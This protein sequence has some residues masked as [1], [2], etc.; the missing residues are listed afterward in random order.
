MP[1]DPFRD[2]TRQIWWQRNEVVA[3]SRFCFSDPIVSFLELLQRLMH[4]EFCP[5]EILDPQYED[6]SR[7]QAADGQNSQDE[8]FS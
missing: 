3:F 6:R 7:P 4:S 5:L 1:S 2:L 8:V